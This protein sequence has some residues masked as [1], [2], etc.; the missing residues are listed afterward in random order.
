MQFS[1][2]YWTLVSILVM[3]YNAPP[4]YNLVAV[5]HPH[6]AANGARKP[7]Q[8]YTEHLLFPGVPPARG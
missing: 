3:I 8:K 2:V 5:K 4:G 7:S 1:Q 6:A